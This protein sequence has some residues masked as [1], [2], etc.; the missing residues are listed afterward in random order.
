MKKVLFLIVSLCCL[1]SMANAQQTSENSD[2]SLKQGIIYQGEVNVGYGF[3]AT[4]E[5]S[6]YSQRYLLFETI[7]GI[8]IS[9]HLF[10]GIGVKMCPDELFNAAYLPIFVDIKYYPINRAFAPYIALDLGYSLQLFGTDLLYV[11]MGRKSKNPFGLHGMAGIGFNYKYLNV[12]LGCQ[13]QQIQ[14]FR[15]NRLDK[16]TLNTSLFLKVGVKFLK[17]IL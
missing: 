14:D 4:Q 11:I 9:P 3:F 15:S 16:K 10:T 6:P 2:R 5:V 1:C 12:G 8:R 7:H 13:I 17:Q